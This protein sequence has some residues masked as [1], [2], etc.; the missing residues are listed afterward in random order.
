VVTGVQK[1]ALPISP[2]PQNPSYLVEYNVKAI[3]TDL[4]RDSQSITGGRAFVPKE[5]ALSYS[6]IE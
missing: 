6:F 2:K 1:C 3:R 5:K 4:S